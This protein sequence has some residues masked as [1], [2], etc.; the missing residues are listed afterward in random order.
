MSDTVH[1]VTAFITREQNG[2]R[3]LLVFQHPNAGIQLP[4]GTVERGEDIEAAVVREAQEETGIQNFHIQTHLGGIENELNEG[5]CII[6][7]TISR[8]P[9][10]SLARC[11][12]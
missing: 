10:S 4:A 7:Q 2:T 11:C 9:S 12:L 1:K 5:E 8:S 6:T 3:E